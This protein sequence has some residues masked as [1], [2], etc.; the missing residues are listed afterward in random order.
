MTPLR[1][2]M[3]ED[4][5][6]RGLAPKTQQASIRAVR[7]LA[8]SYDKSPDR[9]SEEELRLSFLYLYS[10]KHLARSTT[11]ATIV[12][13]GTVVFVIAPSPPPRR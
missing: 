7:Q 11:P 6:L 4:M 2:R 10:E 12:S 5:Q 3:L 13:L 8:S 1:R 9:I